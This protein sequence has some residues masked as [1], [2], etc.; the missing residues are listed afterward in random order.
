MDIKDLSNDDMV[1]LDAFQAICCAVVVYSY[2]MDAVKISEK[3]P[4][5]GSTEKRRDKGRSNDRR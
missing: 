4:K 2:G 5:H 3:K 1:P